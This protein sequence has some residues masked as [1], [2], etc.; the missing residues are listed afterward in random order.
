[1]NKESKYNKKD[2]DFMVRSTK[3]LYFYNYPIKLTKK[4]R[5]NP[6]RVFRDFFL[7]FHLVD[8]RKILWDWMTAAVTCDREPFNEPG[9]RNDVL[10]FYE[11]LEI[12]LE[13][14]YLIYEERRR[15]NPLDEKQ[16]E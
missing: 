16:E 14:A 11:R 3:N 1:M 12:L 13:A 15:R 10:Y 4:Q 8:I 2:R 6:R 9:G 7:D 5:R